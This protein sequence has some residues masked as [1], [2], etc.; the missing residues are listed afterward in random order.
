[1]AV[2]GQCF[3]GGLAKSLIKSTVG[4]MSSDA[5]VTVASNYLVHGGLPGIVGSRQAVWKREMRNGGAGFG[6]LTCTCDWHSWVQIQWLVAHTAMK[7][8]VFAYEQRL[9]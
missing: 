4:S 6:A 3:H 7:W 1:M 2:G 5:K 8:A 9:L